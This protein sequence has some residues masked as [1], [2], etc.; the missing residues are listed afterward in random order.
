MER[1]SRD[2]A[3]AL[4]R[5]HIKNENL[6]R[7]MVATEAILRTLA[8]RFHQN[9]DL[10]G[11]TGLLH[12]IDLEAVHNDMQRHG[13]YAVEEILRP[14]GFPQEGLAAILAHNGE[15]LG[16]EKS[17]DL[18]V[19]LACS[20]TVTGLIVAC[21]L[22]YPSKRIADVRPKSILKR[23]KEKRF[24]ASVDRDAILLC[25]TIGIPLPEFLEL[26]LTAMSQIAEDIGLGGD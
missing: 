15:N 5:H 17:S 2:E 24:A 3:M 13:R 6:V 14:M 21:T 11:L 26:S 20:E 1:P 22:V 10:W 12:D 8:P 23:M 7:H 18:D 16:V 9:P 25:E 4:L 19:A